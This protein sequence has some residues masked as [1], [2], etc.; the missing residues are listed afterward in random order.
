MVTSQIGV[1]YVK[2]W[3]KQSHYITCNLSVLKHS[4]SCALNPSC[5]CLDVMV[6]PCCRPKQ[7]DFLIHVDV[8]SYLR[9]LD[10]QEPA[11]GAA[12]T[13]SAAEEE[14]ESASDGEME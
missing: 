2:A 9:P 7:F 13:G 11:A 3:E 5:S 14:S 1:Q 6:G 10:E 8:T 4:P 12:G